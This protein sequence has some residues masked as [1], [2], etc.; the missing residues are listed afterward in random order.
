MTVQ[1]VAR[2]SV[3]RVVHYADS[4]ARDAADRPVCR[5]AIV[6][7]VVGPAYDP[8]RGGASETSTVAAL[9]VLRPDGAMFLDGVVQAVSGDANTWHWPERT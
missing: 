8:R 3:G 9:A 7:A 1:D 4:T 6:T 5:A 2:P